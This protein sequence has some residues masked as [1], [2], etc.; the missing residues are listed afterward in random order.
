MAS[1][2]AC[3]A[4]SSNGSTSSFLGALAGTDEAESV[5]ITEPVVQVSKTGWFSS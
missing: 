1:Q 4:A 2:V 3:R 5:F